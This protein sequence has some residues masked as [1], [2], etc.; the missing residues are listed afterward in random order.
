MTRNTTTNFSDD[1]KPTFAANL[2]EKD[3]V[4]VMSR[5]DPVPLYAGYVLEIDGS[6]AALKL[7]NGDIFALNSDN[8]YVRYAAAPGQIRP[9]LRYDNSTLVVPWTTELNAA[10][11][12]RRLANMIRGAHWE[13]APVEVIIE[14]EQKIRDFGL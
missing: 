13:R 7:N 6:R 2:R 12:R 1:A 11:H 8:E 3:S 9:D 14:V 4:F 10:Y 5:Y